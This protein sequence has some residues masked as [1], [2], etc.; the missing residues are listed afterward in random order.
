MKYSGVWIP[1][2]RLSPLRPALH[3]W[4]ALNE[5]YC[6]RM[7]WGGRVRDVPF[8][9]NER[10]L[11]GM[12]ACAV[13]M[14]GGLALEEYSSDKRQ[15]KNRKR[16]KKGR[17]DLYLSIGNLECVA[18]AKHLPIRCDI[19][20][21]ERA[22]REPITCALQVAKEAAREDP[23]SGRRLG[24]VFIVPK[25]KVV[26]GEPT[27]ISQPAETFVEAAKHSGPEMLAW[28]FTRRP[29]VAGGLCWPGI[30]VAGD[31]LRRS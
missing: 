26:S 2:K 30:I 29:K 13:A 11:L 4:I 7:R 27:K 25:L 21:T 9:Y 15:G 12:F 24:L 10:P 31:V 16:R 1:Y 28:Y 20:S 8:W 19:D 22:L 5:R 18:E 14:A 3:K 6:S 17:V 23:I